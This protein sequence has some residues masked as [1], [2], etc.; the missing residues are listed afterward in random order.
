MFDD[1]LRSSDALL[2]PQHVAG[3]LQQVEGFTIGGPLTAQPQALTGSFSGDAS[4]EQQ[5]LVKKTSKKKKAKG[6]DWRSNPVTEA[7]SFILNE[8]MKRIRRAEA[9]IM[10]AETQFG[11]FMRDP[12]GNLVPYMQALT[13]KA[14][15][16]LKKDDKRPLNE[17]AVTSLVYAPHAA[18]SDV[19]IADTAWTPD[20]NSTKKIT[21]KFCPSTLAESVVDDETISLSLCYRCR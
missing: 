9:L 13:R 6:G 19:G 10:K 12:E 2:A 7:Q 5:A 14:A 16:E 18:K 11:K 17:P 1:V 8:D 20:L 3:G 21:G 4:T 15:L